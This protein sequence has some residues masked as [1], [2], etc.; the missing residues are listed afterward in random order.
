[1]ISRV[2][3]SVVTVIIV[4][5]LFAAFKNITQTLSRPLN[6]CGRVKRNS[7]TRKSKKLYVPIQNYYFMCRSIIVITINL[8]F[9]THIISSLMHLLM[10]V[11]RIVKKIMK[12]IC[13]MLLFTRATSMTVSWTIRGLMRHV[14]RVSSHPKQSLFIPSW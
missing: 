2:K 12:S 14:L 4:R 1:M 11:D 3:V 7:C 13:S 9:N 10:P 8:Y 6:E 5:P